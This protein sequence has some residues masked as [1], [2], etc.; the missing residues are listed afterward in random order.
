MPIWSSSEVEG[1]VVSADCCLDQSENG[2]SS[3]LADRW[4]SSTEDLTVRG[5]LS[6]G[7]GGVL[8]V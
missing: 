6:R 4:P 5:C 3:R 8:G 7:S 2:L 1:S